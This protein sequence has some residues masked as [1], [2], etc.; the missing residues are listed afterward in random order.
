LHASRQWPTNPV[1]APVQRPA[2]CLYHVTEISVRDRWER[3]ARGEPVPQQ[4]TAAQFDRAPVLALRLAPELG[5]QY[6]RTT[7]GTGHLGCAQFAGP[8]LAAPLERAFDR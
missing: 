3:S 8:N 4:W 1:D 7:V 5:G 6:K 2:G